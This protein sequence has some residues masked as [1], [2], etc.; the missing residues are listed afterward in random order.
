MTP[1]TFPEQTTIFAKDQPEY[2]PLPAHV[3]AAGVVTS[4]W[5]LDD[6]EIAELVETKKL[7]L[8]S[9]TFGGTLQP[10]LPSVVIPEELG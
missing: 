2:Q 3:S 4:C 5:Q 10:L 7:W 6:A 9:H 8:Q 1:I